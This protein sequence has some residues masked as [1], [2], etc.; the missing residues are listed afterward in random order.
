MSLVDQADN[1]P[2]KSLVDIADAGRSLVDKASTA[3]TMSLVDRADSEFTRD[4]ALSP[5]TTLPARN[6]LLGAG[7]SAG[8]GNFWKGVGTTLNILEDEFGFETEMDEKMMEWS[9]Q[10]LN[11]ATVNREG[12]IDDVIFTAG[13]VGVPVAA[14]LTAAAAAPFIGISSAVGAGIA[15]FATAWG[16]NAG[17]FF[18]KEQMEDP[19]FSPDLADVG[20]TGLLATPDLLAGG[21]IRTGSKLLKPIGEAVM[22]TA[23]VTAAKSGLDV[24]STVAQL[25]SYLGTTAKVA[26]TQGAIEG[27]QDFSGSIA[28]AIR[29]DSELDL[30]KIQSM[31]EASAYEAF[32]GG[33]IGV[34]LG[35][36]SAQSQR[37]IA[38]QKKLEAEFE[39]Q[40][41]V[42]IMGEDGKLSEDFT[43]LVMVPGATKQ[44]GMFSLGVQTLMGNATDKA[45]TKLANNPKA[46]ALLQSFNLTHKE[47]GPGKTTINEDARALEGEL[48]TLARAF[49]KSTKGERRAAWDA[50]ALGQSLDTPA[51]KALNEILSNKIPELAKKF[52][53]ID[54]SKGLFTDPTYLPIMNNFNWKKASDSTKIME[55]AKADMEANGKTEKEIEATLRLLSNQIRSYQE[56]GYHM[57]YAVDRDSRKF[58]GEMFEA[59]N[60][61]R[62]EGKPLSD[63]NRK[64]LKSRLSRVSQKT[65]KESPLTLQRSLSNLSQGFLNQYQIHDDPMQALNSHIRMVSEHLSLTNR[66]GEDNRLFDEAVFEIAADAHNND[67]PLS[68]TDVARL[69]DILRTQQRIHLKPL[70]NQ[71][72]RRA[73]QIG[74]AVTN[75]MLLGLSAL[76]SIPEAL[77]IFMNAGGKNALQGLLQSTVGRPGKWGLASEQ[78]GYTISTAVGHGINRTGEESF[79]VGTWENAFIKWTGLPYLQHFL[80]VWAARTFDVS[81]KGM[82]V[83]LNKKNIPVARRN[84]LIKKLS[85]A[86]LDIDKAS[87]WAEQGFPEDTDYFKYEY[88]PS[89][90]GLTQDTIVDPHPV[91]KP[92][93]MND[94]HLL[95]LTQLKGFMTVFTNRVMRTWK[96]KV[97]ADPEGNQQLAT[98]VAPYVAMYIAAQVGMQAVRELIKTGTLD[99]WDEKEI[100]DR[101]MG[102]FGYLGGMAYFI[103]IV[104]SLRFN[105]DPL[106][107]VAGPLPSKTLNVAGDLVQNLDNGNPEDIV[108]DM[109]KQLFPNVPFKDI[110]L[111]G[112]GVE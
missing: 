31:G 27:V 87:N 13:Q 105:S 76:V 107:A 60:K 108:N 54:I 111:E 9:D 68:E 63:K 80:T 15:S 46:Q 109:I 48:Q 30:A 39:G 98:K 81:V 65:L 47:R 95:L 96:Q 71:S 84:R 17:D 16:M 49:N 56:T 77:T 78:L 12:L 72:V 2:R 58:R 57:S 93:W 70:E 102:A 90:I 8:K 14:A 53:G 62:E 106:A 86:G 74:R 33:I 10:N 32:V 51:S 85:E 22:G 21:A 35:G 4:P 29:T 100:E 55:E 92:L 19:D 83:D 7:Y 23:T 5:T 37:T 20:I 88:I 38:K 99:D 73:Q 94:E 6:S 67:T 79:E 43:K 1:A 61:K 110:M 45:K 34:P 3:P 104:N 52:G 64:V 42:D 112:L 69:Y 82:L 97:Q 18:T 11:D 66:F 40:V 89:I 28:A 25:P 24:S 41:A 103:D 59:F 36:L 91:D 26:A 44:P 50:R 101:I 75:T